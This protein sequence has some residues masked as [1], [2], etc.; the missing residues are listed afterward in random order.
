[1]GFGVQNGGCTQPEK[2]SSGFVLQCKPEKI[3]CWILSEAGT[4]SVLVCMCVFFC[5]FLFFLLYF[6][7]PYPMYFHG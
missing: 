2:S 7:T 6:E 4:S 5:F 1:M 3:M